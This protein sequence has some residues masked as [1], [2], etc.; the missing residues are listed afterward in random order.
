MQ[1]QQL[2]ESSSRRQR[3]ANVS[4]KNSE[5]AQRLLLPLKRVG[6]STVYGGRRIILVVRSRRNLGR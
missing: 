3:R 2:P 5:V 6:I 1:Q 4:A